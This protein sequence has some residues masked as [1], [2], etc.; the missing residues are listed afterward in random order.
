M[1]LRLYLD[2][3]ELPEASGNWSM[4][5]AVSSGLELSIV[6][7]AI[8]SIGECSGWREAFYQLKRG[9]KTYS[10]KDLGQLRLGESV[11]ETNHRLTAVLAHLREQGVIPVVL[12]DDHAYAHA[13]YMSFAES[14]TPVKMSNIDA[15]IDAEHTGLSAESVIWNIISEQPGHLKSFAQLGYQQFLNDPSLVNTFEKL[16]FEKYRL[17]EL[18][19]ELEHAEPV[20]RMSDLVSFDIDCLKASE[21]QSKN[22]ENPFGFTAEEAA[23]LCWYAG[24][25]DQLQSFSIL[26]LPKEVSAVSAKVLAVMI[27]YFVEGV[28]HRVDDL[29]FDS[30]SY[31]AYNVLVEGHEGISFYKNRMSA[32]WWVKAASGDIVPCAYADYETAS[33]GDVPLRWMNS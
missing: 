7:I 11:E 23:Q 31:Y 28:Y 2:E 14:G 30:D 12:G 24:V 21:F 8:I 20:L 4:L 9:E 6:D 33:A 22:D 16:S 18:R 13:Q 19:H 3:V 10:L 5:D 17:G 29:K 15:R 32:K 25:S 1:D 27:W 26:N